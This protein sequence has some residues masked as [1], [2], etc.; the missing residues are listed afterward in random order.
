MMSIT[1]INTI[2][3]V[4]DLFHSAFKREER[5][6]DL[7]RELDRAKQE[8]KGLKDKHDGGKNKKE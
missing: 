7:R 3:F 1:G 2:I 4:E 5:I 8:I 6:R